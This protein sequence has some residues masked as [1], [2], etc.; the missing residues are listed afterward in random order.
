MRLKLALRLL[1]LY[2]ALP[3]VAFAPKPSG[4]ASRN[5]C[6][7]DQNGSPEALQE[8]SLSLTRM[9]DNPSQYS[10]VISDTD[11]HVVSGSFSVDQLEILRTIMTE[12]EKFALSDE[13]VGSKAPITTRFMDRREP[14]FMVD[15]EKVG[16]QS[17]LFLTL[18]TE[19]GSITTDS[20]KAIRSSRRKEGVFFDLLSRL[21]STLPTPNQPK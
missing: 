18:T 6:G 21:E 10:L 16:N 4:A 1:T 2:I 9:K 5:P 17:R 3:L 13:A 19:I 7:H 20:G 12:A 11:E 15:V 8:V 14:A